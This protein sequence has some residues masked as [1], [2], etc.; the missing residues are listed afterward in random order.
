[1]TVHICAL[2]NTALGSCSCKHASRGAMMALP[3]M[4]DACARCASNIWRYVITWTF[5]PTLCSCG[6]CRPLLSVPVVHFT[7]KIKSASQSASEDS[8]RPQCIALPI[9]K[10]P[11][12]RAALLQMLKGLAANAE[13]APLSGHRVW[14]R[15]D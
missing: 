1:M 4:S 14:T 11:C 10:G 3:S 15:S 6:A 13:S 7:P 9:E 12:V 8:Q 2:V 5:S